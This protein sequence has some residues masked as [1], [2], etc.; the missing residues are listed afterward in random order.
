[1]SKIDELYALV[2]KSLEN[3]STPYEVVNVVFQALVDFSENLNEDDKVRFFSNLVD[4]LNKSNL[5]LEK[6][7]EIEVET[8]KKLYPLYKMITDKNVNYLVEK[9][10]NIARRIARTNQ[11]I[12]DALEKASFRIINLA[13]LGN[14]DEVQY[15]ITR[16]FLVHRVP[17]DSEL[18][19][20]F[21]P[22]YDLETFR[23]LVYSFI[24]GIIQREIIK[25]EV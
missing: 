10:N 8:N 17:M 4:S 25:E 6:I 1:M 13:R 18:I 14:R 16:I 7:L 19:E 3:N 22:S 20:I 21:K 23:T 5:E 2:K 9:V 11:N 12:L 24:S 15:I